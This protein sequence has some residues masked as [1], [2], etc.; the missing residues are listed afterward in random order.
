MFEKRFSDSIMQRLF[1]AIFRLKPSRSKYSKTWD[2]SIVLDIAATC[3]PRNA[4][5][6]KNLSEKLI[7]LLAF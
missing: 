2:I 6:I 3:F 4:Q 1:Q 5:K 7:I